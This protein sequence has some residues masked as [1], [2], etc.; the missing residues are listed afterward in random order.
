M[1]IPTSVFIVPYRA[2][3]N[4]K[5]DFLKKMKVIL[6]DLTEPYEIYFAHQCDNRPFNRGAMKNLGFIAIKNKYPQNYKDITFIFNDV[7]TFPNEKGMIDYITTPGVVKHYYGFTFALGGIF[8]IKG[9]D[10]EKAKGFPNFWGWGLEDNLMNERCVSVGLTIDR[11]SFYDIKDMRINRP[12][13]GFQRTVSKRDANVYKYENP[14]NMNDL[15]TINY[16]IQNEFINIT[17]FD[18]VMK[19]NEQ[20]YY[21]YD[22]RQGSKIIIDGRYKRRIWTMN[23]MFS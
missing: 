22:I 15:T 1:N 5:A 3:P 23:K 19:H 18:C 9:S 8:S 16:T 20:V 17:N 2:R 11:S 14:D 4:Q 10:F 6:E 7:D 12:F 21:S 13:D